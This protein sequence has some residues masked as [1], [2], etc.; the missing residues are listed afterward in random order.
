MQRPIS[1]KLNEKYTKNMSAHMTQHTENPSEFFQIAQISNDPESL[2]KA[3]DFLYTHEP[4]CLYLIGNLE[5][6]GPIP[7]DH[8]HSGNF[9]QVSTNN[10]ITA[11]FCACNSGLVLAFTS[12]PS[13]SSDLFDSIL[14][15]LLNNP[16]KIL[17]ILAEENTAQHLLSSFTRR[18]GEGFRVKFESFNE[19]LK[20][21]DLKLNCWEAFG[22]TDQDGQV[23][24]LRAEDYPSWLELMTKFQEETQ[25]ASDPEEMQVSI[26]EHEAG[27]KHIWGYFDKKGGE[28]VCIVRLNSCTRAGGCFGG[29][30]NKPEFRRRGIARK[31]MRQALSDCARIHG[32][33]HNVLFTSETNFSA[34][35]LYHSLGYSKIGRIRISF[36]EFSS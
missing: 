3:L 25:I 10:S 24:F 27:L 2:S 5:K 18:F 4:F 6:F 9:F 31:L 1:L 32:H 21:N 19:L 34:L 26:F 35:S 29:M 16:T 36:F 20:L 12:P 23:R 30:Y 28:L 11:V 13:P 7:T 33:G 15:K 8:P 17:G 22:N 14:S